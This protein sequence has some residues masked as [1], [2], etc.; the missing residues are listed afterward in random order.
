MIFPRGRTG[1]IPLEGMPASVLDLFEE[2]RAVGMISPRSAAALLRLALQ[3]LIDE[4][5]PGNKNLNEKIGALKARGLADDVVKAMDVVRVVGNN[6]VHPGDIDVNE[7]S[8]I[9]PALFALV[10]VIVE[11]VV[12][13]RSTVDALFAKLPPGALEAIARRDAPRA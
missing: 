10:N 13:R 3:T 5:E 2:A 4:L 12:V 7:D 11:Q 6:G 8:A 9:L 1:V